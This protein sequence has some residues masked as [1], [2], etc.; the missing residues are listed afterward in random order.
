VSK[1]RILVIDDDPSLHEDIRL[2]L[3]PEARDP[4]FDQETDF[5]FGARPERSNLPEFDV[6]VAFQGK[7]GL[8]MA[9]DAVAEGRPFS[10]GFIDMRMPPGWDGL[11]TIE[12][13]WE[14]DPGLQLVLCT[15]YSD[16]TWQEIT[17]RLIFLE[18][19][20]ILRKPY[21]QA[22]VRQMAC[23]LSSKRRLS[24]LARLKM[25]DLARMVDDRTRE[26]EEARH[27]AEAAH[28]VKTNFLVT[29]AHE[30]R[31]PLNNIL[32][33]ADLMATEQH[34]SHTL[35]QLRLMSVS[36]QSL[37][38]LIDEVLDHQ[39]I[40]AGYAKFD[41]IVFNLRDV[42]SD[43]AG[44]HA[45]MAGQKGLD[46]T[47]EFDGITEWVKGD[48]AKLSRVL[49]NLLSN[50]VTC[51][52]SG[53]IRL[54][55][56]A[57]EMGLTFEVHDTG[58]GIPAE[59]Q[60]AIFEP[61]RQA[62]RLD[63]P[64]GG[65]GL[66]L[67]I[68]R[69]LVEVMGGELTVESRL[70]EGSLFSFTV[71]LPEA[72]APR[73]IDPGQTKFVDLAETTVL[74]VDNEPICRMVTRAMLSKM[75][76]EVIVAKEGQE[77]LEKLKSAP[78]DLVLLDLRMPVLDGYGTISRIRKS[79]ADYARVPVVAVT[80][81]AGEDERQRCLELGMDAYAKKPVRMESL[82]RAIRE[83]RGKRAQ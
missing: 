77:A 41:P 78:I 1:F 29:M 61:Y 16:H 83:A 74:V 72:P 30:M 8:K 49:T 36:G 68:S 51:T 7:D 3:C 47:A 64:T 9:Q 43:L 21:D 22:E 32:G 33:L 35:E 2:Y 58:I 67:A 17:Q 37:V 24:G 6:Q 75:G 79:D 11:E 70:G 20:L 66:G 54:R 39:K 12:R 46:L 27:S 55:V 80:A 10:V 56:V 81:E 73:R 14:L 44:T 5:L 19:L 31:T 57:K 26:L 23:A 28:R 50:A 18:N 42:I 38:A 25:D 59:E 40:E 60:E 63:R 52:V 15:A 69:H 65:T 76:A 71:P 4:A 13:L 62:T 34:P 45:V 53:Q 82:S 48:F